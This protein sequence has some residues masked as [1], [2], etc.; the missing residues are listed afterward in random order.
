MPENQQSPIVTKAIDITETYMHRYGSCSIH[1]YR[2]PLIPDF[3]G[4]LDTMRITFLRKGIVSAYLWLNNPDINSFFLV[5][6]ERGSFGGQFD[7]E[8]KRII[9]RLWHRHSQQAYYELETIR[10]TPENQW[11]I[12]DRLARYLLALG[13]RQNA[14]P[15]IPLK[16]HQRSYSSSQV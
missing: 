15:S 3:S 4:F 1:I 11:N 13:T 14:G 5:I 16:W 9:S 12:K 6:W 2:F 10:I 7:L 8:A